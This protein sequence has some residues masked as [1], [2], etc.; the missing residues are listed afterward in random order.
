MRQYAH[1]IFTFQ[2]NERELAS[3]DNINIYSI[4]VGLRDKFELESLAT[5]PENVMTVSRIQELDSSIDE[6]KRKIFACKLK[7]LFLL[8]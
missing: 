2:Q 6:I 7:A 1:A 4:G 5:A 3:R 8:K